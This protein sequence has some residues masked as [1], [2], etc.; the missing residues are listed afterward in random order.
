MTVRFEGTDNYVVT[1]DL[2]MAVN[3]AVTLGRPRKRQAGFPHR[4]VEFRQ[5]RDAVSIQSD[6][7]SVVET[8]VERDVVGDPIA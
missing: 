4:V 8:A 1:K 3:A 2:M 6:A 7:S 5:W